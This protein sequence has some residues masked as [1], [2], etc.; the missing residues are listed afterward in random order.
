MRKALKAL[1]DAG[2][3]V[4]WR[5]GRGIPPGAKWHAGHDDNDRTVYRGVECPPCNVKTAARKGARKRNAAERAT[6]VRL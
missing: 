6:R 2:R 3:G 5:C 4:C 1:V